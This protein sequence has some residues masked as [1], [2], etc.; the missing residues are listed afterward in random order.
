MGEEG[1]PSNV[2]EMVVKVDHFL[3]PPFS[4]V[5]HEQLWHC[6]SI[7]QQVGNTGL[8]PRLPVLPHIKLHAIEVT[9]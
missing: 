1:S 9:S 7:R 6:G 3:M 8:A 2:V 5:F 4:V